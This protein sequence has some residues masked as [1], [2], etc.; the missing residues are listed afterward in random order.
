MDVGEVRIKE[1]ISMIR[2]TYSI[3]KE[4]MKED[5]CKV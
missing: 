1:K 2:M 4:E 3:L 5:V